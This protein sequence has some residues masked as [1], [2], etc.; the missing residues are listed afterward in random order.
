MVLVVDNAPYNYER[1]VGSLSA[2]KENNS[3]AREKML[4]KIGTWIVMCTPLLICFVNC[5]LIVKKCGRLVWKIARTKLVSICEGI[6]GQIGLLVVDDTFKYKSVML[7]IGALVVLTKYV[8]EDV[9]FFHPKM[10]K[11][12]K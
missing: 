12:V 5:P 3:I 8:E 11:S 4:E 10:F 1:E 2:G 6:E 7:S 9:D